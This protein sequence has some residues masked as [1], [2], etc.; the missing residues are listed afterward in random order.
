[1][2]EIWHFSM[3]LDIVMLDK[4]I[5]IVAGQSFAAAAAASGAEHSNT[6][7]KYK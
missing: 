7:E 1:M 4:S 3:K 6:Y 5:V 2:L